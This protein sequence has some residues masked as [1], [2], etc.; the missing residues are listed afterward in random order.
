MFGVQSPTDGVHVLPNLTP[1]KATLV[2]VP[3]H[4]MDQW[5]KE[6]DKFVGPGLVT[7]ILRALLTFRVCS[8]KFVCVPTVD[9]MKKL[10]LKQLLETDLVLISQNLFLSTKYQV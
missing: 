3:S 9:T 5:R 4:L 2:V 8:L 7:S 6:V 1:T 10:T